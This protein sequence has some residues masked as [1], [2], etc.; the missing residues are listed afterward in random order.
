[1]VVDGRETACGSSI[2]NRGGILCA[3][4]YARYL[5]AKV[6]KSQKDIST[7]RVEHHVIFEFY[8]CKC[9]VEL[10]TL[11]FL[12]QRILEVYR[13]SDLSPGK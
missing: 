5:H 6:R 1:M 13:A 3:L 9:Y 8:E 2:G 7:N 11:Q 10:P 4:R 12:T